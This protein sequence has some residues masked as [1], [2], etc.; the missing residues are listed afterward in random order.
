MTSFALVVAIVLA[1]TAVLARGLHLMP[2]T[3][4]NRAAAD[5]GGGVLSSLRGGH[6]DL[7][8]RTAASGPLGRPLPPGARN[9]AGAP[10]RNP[11]GGGRSH[12]ASPSVVTAVPVS[13]TEIKLAW[14]DVGN[15]TGYMVER[16]LGRPTA[17]V[18]I[19]TTGRG[20]TTYN[21]VGLPSGTTYFYRV[22]ATDAGSVSDPS[23]IASSTTITLP[24][25]PGA[26][27]AVA[28]SSSEIDLAWADVADE[29]GF[30]IE[31]SSDGATGWVEIATTGQGVTSYSDAGLSTGTAYYYRVFATDAGGDS[32]ASD[33][34][35][36][37]T[38]S[39]SST[40][41]ATPG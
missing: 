28:A 29:T 17:W 38:Q 18:T 39:D 41:S 3:R 5:I 6:P 7:R 19:A 35:S 8:G 2:G 15:E 9:A 25:S 22:V 37:S 21:D 20:V 24:A 30:R 13:A 27:T 16:S 1:G 36:A 10:G 33:V 4:E 14:T 40:T 26:L 11:T 12:P 31:R 23:D 32:P 34:V